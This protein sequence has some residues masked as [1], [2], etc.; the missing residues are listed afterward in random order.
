MFRNQTDLS[1][2]GVCQIPLGLSFLI[3]KMLTMQG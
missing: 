3:H 1:S 2:D